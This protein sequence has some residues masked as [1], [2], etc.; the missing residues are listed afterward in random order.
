M[1][2]DI[3]PVL[4]TTFTTS[5]K[6]YENKIKSGLWTAF[7]ITKFLLY[8]SLLDEECGPQVW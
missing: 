8:E 1:P 5:T 2:Q 4:I 6:L 3:I 7:F